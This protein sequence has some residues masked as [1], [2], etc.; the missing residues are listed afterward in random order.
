VRA[1]PRV[2]GVRV[3]RIDAILDV[4]L[5]DA[6][7]RRAGFVFFTLCAAAGGEFENQKLL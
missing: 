2:E 6:H 5:G 7:P 4:K 3:S 1:E